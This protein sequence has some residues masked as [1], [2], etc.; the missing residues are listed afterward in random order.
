[1]EEPWAGAGV[2]GG[3]AGAASAQSRRYRVRR[4]LGGG[5]FGEVLLAEDTQAAGAAETVAL[6]RV[7]VRGEHRHRAGP[8]HTLPENVMREVMTCL[9]V[10]HANVVRVSDFF[11]EGAMLN[12]VF[13]YCPTSL[14]DLVQRHAGAFGRAEVKCI[15]QQ[16]LR[17]VRACHRTGVLHRDIKP[18][19][20]MLTEDGAVKVADFGLARMADP[21]SSAARPAYTHTVATRWYRAP[22][23]LYGAREYGAAVDVWSVGCILVELLI[24]CPMVP[25]ETDIEQL[26]KV[27]QIF[28]PADEATWPGVSAL[29]DFDKIT[30]GHIEHTAL[31]DLYPAVPA[32]EMAFALKLLALNPADRISAE[33]ALLDDY[34][35]LD[36]L[37]DAGRAALAARCRAA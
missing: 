34:F 19:N 23:L 20:V 4:A 7:F 30:F 5:A 9:A 36:P 26:G 16:L 11:V 22:E 3:R 13:E 14:G 17:G 35:F 28:G 25:G 24:G 31:A 37:P 12:I 21:S 6:K 1:M 10:D 33:D 32:A 27:L 15:V 8:T 2:W 29:P 18:W